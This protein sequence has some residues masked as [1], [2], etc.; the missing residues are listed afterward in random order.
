MSVQR[1]TNIF[2]GNS[3]LRNLRPLLALDIYTSVIF[4]QID[5]ARSR[6]GSRL[7]EMR[8]TN[9]EESM[10]YSVANSSKN[11]GIAKFKLDFGYTENTTILAY[12]TNSLQVFSRL[13]IRVFHN[14]GYVYDWDRRTGHATTGVKRKIPIGTNYCVSDLDNGTTKQKTG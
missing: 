13:G 8:T 5:E 6:A 12:P 14:K 2:E 4:I 7:N 1:P 10:R 3:W 11:T 9:L